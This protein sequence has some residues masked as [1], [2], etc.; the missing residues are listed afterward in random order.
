MDVVT[1][2]IIAV[3]LLVVAYAVFLYVRTG[4]GKK[5]K[6]LCNSCEGQV[7]NNARKC[8]HCGEPNPHGKVG[9]GK[10]AGAIFIVLVFVGFI[11]RSATPRVAGDMT[12]GDICSTTGYILQKQLAPAFKMHTV[13]C[14]AVSIGN[15]LV[16][17]HGG[18]I[19]PLA[20]DEPIH[21]TARGAV[22]GD[23]LRIDEIDVHG[24]TKGFIP[25]EKFGYQ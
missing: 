21:Y 20:P 12:S 1:N 15:G 11:E 7:S 25:Y 23:S 5:K 14:N 10:I 9:I 16:E 22:H 2:A 8:P 4:T 13:P 24:I 19:S 6:G 3:L 17:I 18:Y